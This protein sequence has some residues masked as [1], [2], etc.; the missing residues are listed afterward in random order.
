MLEYDADMNEKQSVFE[1]ALRKEHEEIK[2]LIIGGLNAT[3]TTT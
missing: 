2:G 3:R 1:L